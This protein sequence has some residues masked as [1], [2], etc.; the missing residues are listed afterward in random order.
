MRSE[1][2]GEKPPKANWLLALV[3]VVLLG[4]AYYLAIT[5]Q[6]PVTAMVLFLS[7]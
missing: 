2:V 6:D 5:I 4:G 1:A 3:G 7:L